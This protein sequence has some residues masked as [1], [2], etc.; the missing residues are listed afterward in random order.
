MVLKLKLN[1]LKS[2][3]T[4]FVL[5]FSFFS[6]KSQFSLTGSVKNEKGEMLTFATVFLENTSFAASSDERGNYI[7]KDIPFGEYNFKIIFIGYVTFQ[8][9]VLI[10]S[11]KVFNIILQGEIYNLDQIEIQANRVADNGPFTKSNLNK[12]ALQKENLGQDVPFLLQWSPSMVV[13]SDAGAGIGYTSMRLRGSDQTRIN[14][15]INGVPLNDAE[16]QNVFWVDL[17]DLMG[18]VNNVQIQRGV[19]TSTNGSG[20]FGGTVSINTSDTKINPYIEIAGGVGSF[21]TKKIS[22]NVGTGLINKKFMLD[23]RFSII[24]SDGYVDRASADLSSMF[25]SAA[26]VTAKSS[27]KLNILSGKEVTYQAW[28]GVPWEKIYGTQQSLL[29][30]YN[31]NKGSIYKSNLD[32]VNLFDSDRRYNFYTYPDQVDNYRQTHIQL[33]HSVL[34]NKKTKLKST[35]FYTKGKGFFEEF[36]YNDK[37]ENY[38][39]NAIMPQIGEEIT[40]ADIVRRRWLD[41]DFIGFNSDIEHTIAKKW[42]LQGGVSTSYYSGTH[43]G[44]LIKLSINHPDHDKRKKYYDNTGQK[45]DLSSYLRLI[46]DITDRFS[47]HSDLQLRH[48]RY[49]VHGIDNDLK[50]IKVNYND[51]FFN[52]KF[53]FSYSLKNNHFLYLSYAIAHKEPSRGDFIDNTFSELPV[54]EKLKNLELGYKAIL[55]SRF[56]MESNIYFM[57]YNDQLVLTGELND[58]G[59]PVRINVPNSY[60]V[61]WEGSFAAD[62]SDQWA[63]QANLNLSQNKISSFKETLVDYTDGFAKKIVQHANTEIS[64]SPAVVGAIQLVFR[65]IPGLETELSSK[66][67]SIQYLDNTSDQNRKLPSYHYQNLRMAKE[68][69]SKYWKTCRA[70]LSVNN[71]LN[72]NYSANGYTYSY[73]YGEL[74]TENFV[75]PQAGRYF[76]FGIIVGF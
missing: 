17:P 51:L 61:G 19:G 14:V 43:F 75:Y 13:T 62:L 50:N 21:N 4:L 46:Y 38:Q 18:S 65:P 10:N 37:F 20:A 32:S 33:I 42:K 72:Y 59:A 23:G 29:K 28:N 52:P 30:H 1:L 34:L 47:V 64:F 22:V 40:E 12:K 24:K 35:L 74:I 66:F 11:N 25:F 60:R 57:K 2:Y 16:S 41:N 76:L 71:I 54:R 39:L 67:V 56:Q 26:R 55:S 31:N 70:T 69:K 73:I 45:S 6:L 58:V 49:T 63:L 3:L 7:I 8:Q 15:T 27:L 68:I 44:N 36:R 48:I 9:K 5:L 53:G